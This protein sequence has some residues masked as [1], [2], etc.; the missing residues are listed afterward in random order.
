MD[1]N[2]D[3]PTEQMMQARRQ[4]EQKTSLA[5][6]DYVTSSLRHQSRPRATRPRAR[7]IP[8]AEFRQLVRRVR[9][10]ELLPAL[11]ALTLADSAEP[12]EPSPRNLNAHPW[13]LAVAARE[14]ILWGNEHRD[15]T[16]NGEYLRR[17]FNAFTNIAEPD[18]SAEATI[19]EWLAVMT[20]LAYEQFPYQESIFEEVSRTHALMVEGITEIDLEVLNDEAVWER[21]VGAPLGQA[22]GATFF[23]Q[24]AANSNAGWWDTAWLNRNDLQDIYDTWPRKVIE[25]RAV[26]LTSTVEDF[27]NAYDAVPKPP[28]GHERF[29]YNPLAARPFIHM[30]DGR[31]LA[32]QPRLI[33]RTISPG[34]LY[35]RGIAEYGE[36]FARDLG[37]LTE[38]YV[39]ELLTNIDPRPELHPE[40]TYGKNNAKSTDWFLVL[41]NL[42]VML[43]VKSARYGLLERAATP[44]F[45]DR[46]TN[47]F[48]KAIKQLATT[49]EHLDNNH[50]RFKHIPNDRLRIGIIVTGEPHYLANSDWMR[51]RLDP[52]PIPTLVASLRDIEQLAGLPL[53]HVETQL[54]A[55]AN[56]PERSTWTLDTALNDAPDQGRSPV[57][58]RAWDSY[59]WVADDSPVAS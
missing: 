28:T 36:P 16:I 58:Q 46:S 59:P 14:S 55:I 19:E 29:A 30:P 40:I 18:A 5:V 24:A 4:A 21:L 1:T 26:D 3:A 56:D 17:L 22:V 33:L 8:F 6:T 43:E 39:G 38:R 11:A 41:P 51:Q 27:K 13:A 25:Q 48:N 44:G 53:H 49:N 23:L 15:D 42:V 35:Y 9:P 32:P 20:R 10:S 45:L 50:D 47:L 57:L 2:A 31:A 34:G 37:H 12:Y 54:T 52:T 7:S